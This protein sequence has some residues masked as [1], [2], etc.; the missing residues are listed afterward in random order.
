MTTND[1]PTVI[2]RQIHKTFHTPREHLAILR[3]IDLSLRAGESVAVM[4]PS[5]SGKSTLLNIMGA[6]E[7]PDSGTLTV[8]GTNPFSLSPREIARFRNRTVG[9]V[10]QEHHLLPQC[11]VWEN[12]LIPTLA[13]P[14]GID[15]DQTARRATLLLRRVGL[16]ERIEHRPAELS[17]G[18]RQRVA[19]ARALI[20]EPA[21]LLAD[22]PTGNLDRNTADAVADLLVDLCQT[23][24]P[25]LIVVTHAETLARRFDR[26]LELVNGVLHPRD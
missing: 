19:I 3:G 15:A 18:E 22:E 9:F 23:E 5:G 17:G 1:P 26:T 11:T 6:L 12:V 16:S 7:P 20:N 10:F 21:L 8:N 25:A 14:G 13:F 24:R 2:A 4:G